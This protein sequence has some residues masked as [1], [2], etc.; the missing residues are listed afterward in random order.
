MDSTRMS[1][2]ARAADL[3]SAPARLDI[4]ISGLRESTAQQPAAPT[5][6]PVVLMEINA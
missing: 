3:P 1:I 4:S 5:A 6:A 2:T